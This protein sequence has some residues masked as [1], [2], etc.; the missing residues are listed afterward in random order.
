MAIEIGGP[1]DLYNL[2]SDLGQT[3]DAGLNGTAS[4][5]KRLG[6]TLLVHPYGKPQERMDAI[7][8]GPREDSVVAMKEVLARWDAEP[9]V[10]SE[11]MQ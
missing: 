4:G 9:A 11:T 7:S 2:L 8:N 6:F 5:A 10:E 1:S 3:I